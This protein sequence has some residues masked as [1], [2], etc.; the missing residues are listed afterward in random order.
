MEPV[1]K[2][3]PSDDLYW[4]DP[5]PETSHA[6]YGA[7][8][9]VLQRQPMLSR[10]LKRHGFTLVELLVVIAIIGMLVALLLPA[11]QAAREAARRAYCLNNLKHIGLGLANYES[12]LRAL[13]AS[14]LRPNGFVDDG[15][16]EPR[17]NWAISILPLLEQSSL[18]SGFD[19]RVSVHSTV[20]EPVRTARVVTYQCPSDPG[21]SGEFLPLL[22]IRYARGNYA[23]NYGAAS[24]GIRFWKEARYRGVMGQN[25]FTKLAQIT[26]GLSNTVAVGEVLAHPNR[27][28]NRGVWA[29]HAPGAASMGLDCDTKCQGIEGPP[30]R[31]WIPFC[32]AGDSQFSCSFQNNAES[33]A[34]PRSKHTGGAQFV[35]CDGSTRFLAKTIDTSVLVAAFTS[36]ASDVAKLGE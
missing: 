7:S 22:G 25:V 23:A 19:S 34:G 21:N 35:F 33:N 26:D 36:V 2:V 15:R 18:F 32:A 17:I 24:W 3:D 28:D 27:L 8:A 1:Y 14:A 29:F 4:F 11:V 5:L 20:N 13:P 30:S 6:K 9:I 10:R 16:D 31:E 12:A